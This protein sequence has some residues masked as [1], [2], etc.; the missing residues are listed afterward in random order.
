M[1]S[2][3]PTPLDHAHRRGIVHRD[4]KP[5]NVVLTKA[6]AKLLDFGLAK[7]HTAAA[8]ALGAA[9]TAQAAE[10]L[11]DTG[12]IV[13]TLHYM[14]P[15]Q[16][17]G[18]EVDARTD[19]FAFAVVVYEM[20]TGRRPFAGDSSAGVMAAILGTQPPAIATV[21]RL[22]PPALDHVVATCL[23]KD[24]DARWQSA[25]DVARELRWIAESS[26]NPSS[27]V[28]AASQRS[29]RKPVIAA[30]ALL[31]SV[32]VGAAAG[33]AWLRVQPLAADPVVRTQILAPAGASLAFDANP[34][35]SRLMASPRVRRRAS[36]CQSVY[37][38]RLDQFEAT[39]IVGT[40]ALGPFFTG[41]P[42]A[43]FHCRWEVEEELPSAAVHHRRSAT[44]TR[45]W[46][47]PGDRTTRSFHEAISSR[48]PNAPRPAARRKR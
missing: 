36:R 32:L 3:S 22:A 24:P 12:L 8:S 41:Q 48:S 30:V 43:R 26:A 37:L 44:R 47:Q 35:P 19:L 4:L 1:P 40:G 10:S 33:C 28:T 16:L 17:E 42:L 13:G 20:M 45:R 31:A 15:E 11:T 23:A 39:P 25:G 5:G 29:R 2:K 34:L 18:K 14:A 6:G 21:N 7:W 38:Q 27:T 9:R 46:A